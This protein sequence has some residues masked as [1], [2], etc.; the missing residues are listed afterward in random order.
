[1]IKIA[2][3]QHSA[4]I[5]SKG[6]LFIWG[7]GLFGTFLSP[8]RMYSISNSIKDLKIG[9]SFGIALDNENKLWGWGTNSLGE[10]GIK[11]MAGKAN[12]TLI[13]LRD[14]PITFSCGGSHCV[15]ACEDSTAPLLQTNQMSITNILQDE[16][17]IS[18]PSSPTSP[19]SEASR[20]V[21]K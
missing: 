14:K 13:E 19:R 9:G 10:L 15:V 11:D 21:L 12:P 18:C 4:A 2:C 7:T 5:S 3:G 6:I 1:M 20:Q 17:K 16:M 8:K